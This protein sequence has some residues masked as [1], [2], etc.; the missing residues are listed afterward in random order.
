M[1]YTDPIQKLE[2]QRQLYQQVLPV[3]KEKQH[4][5]G[6]VEVQNQLFHNRENAKSTD[7]FVKNDVLLKTSEFADL[8]RKSYGVPSKVSDD[9]V[10]KALTNGDP[11]F[12]NKF[13]RYL[14]GDM[15]VLREMGM[16]S[17]DDTQELEQEQ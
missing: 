3:I 9:E 1:G 15:S 4:K 13:T 6:R 5:I 16:Q 12:Q 11:D 10:I 17:E 14:N 2:K 7:D 8:F